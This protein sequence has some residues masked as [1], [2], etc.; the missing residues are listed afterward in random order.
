MLGHKASHGKFK[1]IEIV[2]SISSDHNTM[3]LDIKNKKKKKKTAKN[4]KWRLNN[5]LQDNEWISEQIKK[6]IKKKNL[7]TNENENMMIQNQW[8]VAKEILSG[9]F[10]AIKSYLGQKEK[11]QI[12]NVTL[13]LKQ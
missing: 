7:E 4:T 10:I 1:K 12:N 8:D 11:S 9:K 3:R 2:S 6:Q 13:H 5:M